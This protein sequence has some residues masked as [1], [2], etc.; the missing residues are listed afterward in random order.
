V[1]FAG[2]VMRIFSYLFHAFLA[3]FLFGVSMLALLNGTHNLKMSMLPWEGKSLT[4]WMLALGLFGLASV[5]LAVRGTLRILLLVWSVAVVLVLLR[6]YIFSA[7]HFRT[8]GSFLNAIWFILAAVLAALGSW[9]RY[10]EPV[11]HPL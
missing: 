9:L 8:F 5:W 1:R 4:F 2:A 6:G 3:F 11:N 7:Y 10:R